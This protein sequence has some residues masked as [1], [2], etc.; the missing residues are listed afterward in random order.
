MYN[1]KIHIFP[2]DLDQCA[3]SDL[4]STAV[5]PAGGMGV[6]VTLLCFAPSAISFSHSHRHEPLGKLRSAMKLIHGR[7]IG[8]GLPAVSM[9]FDV[10]TAPVAL[11]GILT[12]EQ[13]HWLHDGVYVQVG[14]V[15]QNRT[16]DDGI[17]TSIATSM[18]LYD[19]LVIR[20]GSNHTC[21]HEP[22]E[23][24]ADRVRNLRMAMGRHFHEGSL[25][26]DKRLLGFRDKAAVMC[27]AAL[28]GEDPINAYHSFLAE[29]K[30]YF[31]DLEPRDSV[32][33]YETYVTIEGG[34]E[35]ARW[36]AAS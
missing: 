17:G 34:P 2:F 27:R 10:V 5:C 14:F 13:E 36:T 3:Y 7:P 15:D 22:L 6:I 35:H 26:F 32:Q 9:D 8:H 12:P 11:R 31:L 30:P 16:T 19:H 20:H 21:D 1:P 28:G 18:T 33:E 29:S 4:S 25:I 23:L 24:P